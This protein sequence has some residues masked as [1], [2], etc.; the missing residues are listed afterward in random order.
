M[1]VKIFKSVK[2]VPLIFLLLCF[3]LLIPLHV[4][5]ETPST[6]QAI[7][8]IEAQKKEIEEETAKL[9]EELRLL[10][11]EQADAQ[12][13]SDLLEEKINLLTT[14]IN[15]AIENIKMLNQE[16]DI[17]EADIQ[18]ADKKYEDTFNLLKERLLALYITGEENPL[19]TLLNSDNLYEY[20][21][22]QEAL[23]T[24]SDHDKK[25]MDKITDYRNETEDDKIQLQKAKDLLAE[26]KVQLELDQFEQE[27][28]HKQN[29]E[30]LKQIATTKET[31][32]EQIRTLAAEDEQLN[33][34]LEAAIEAERIRQ[35]EEE[36]KRKEEEERKR[37]EAEKAAT[38]GNT[39]NSNYTP[40]GSNSGSY[41]QG[42]DA[43]WPVPG[44]GLSH[45]TYWYGNGHNGLDIGA[46]QG[47]PVVATEDGKVL[48][49]SFHSSWGNNVLIYH[50]STYSSRYAHLTSWAV[51][52]GEFVSKGQVIGYVGNTGYSFGNHLHFEI[53]KD[54]TRIDPY[55]YLVE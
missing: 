43:A 21:L 45:I 44:R 37:L 1:N 11:I 12:A 16:I 48:S 40:A 20:S 39:S 5:T 52:Q 3:A 47:T 31:K 32:E 24:I 22:R 28:L 46:P 38:A 10:D 33:A 26:E 41:A 18:A 14:K 13:Y 54:G 25:L 27:D 49:S 9:D 30:L 2:V 50:N 35:E 55:P 42:F 51:T 29:N 7:S 53:Y 6:V 23:K 8:D 15:N 4:F 17:M 36:R 34:E 19:N